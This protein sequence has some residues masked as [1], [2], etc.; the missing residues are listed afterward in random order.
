MRQAESRADLGGEQAHEP[1]LTES[2]EQVEDKAEGEDI[3]ERSKKL[4]V[5]EQ[6]SKRLREAIESG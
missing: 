1:R 6:L 2:G 5:A 3:T 4:T